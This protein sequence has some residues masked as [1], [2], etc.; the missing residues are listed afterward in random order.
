MITD[1]TESV[2]AE[3]SKNELIAN[4]TH[5]MNTPLTAIK[6]FAELL[7][8]G[9]LPVERAQQAAETILRQSDRLAKLIK[10]ILDFSA[11]DNDE[12]PPYAVDL[13]ALLVESAALFEPRLREKNIAFSLQAE[14]GV[15]I[16]TRRERLIEIVNNLIG[17]GIRYNREGGS[18]TVTLTGG[19]VPELIVADTGIGIPEENLSHI[20]SR[21]YTVDP[22]HNG[23]GGGFGLGLAIVRKLCRRAGWDLSVKSRVGEGT[24]FKIIFHPPAKSSAPQNVK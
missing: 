12:L 11:I 2:S 24:A 8:G 19:A 21:F 3:R 22:S 14:S 18:L 16:L 5:E 10:S 1:I 15:T 4:V 6:G 23:E 17:N 9:N 7:A 20:F 13:S